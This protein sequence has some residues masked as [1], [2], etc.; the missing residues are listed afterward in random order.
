MSKLAASSL[1]HVSPIHATHEVADSPVPRGKRMLA[2]V[3]TGWWLIALAGQTI[4]TGYVATLYGVA[5]L[6]GDFPRWNDVMPRGWVSADVGGNIA[7]AAHLFFAAVVFA[8]GALQLSARVRRNA[9][10]LHRWN[11][12]FYLIAAAVLATT[13]L[14]LVFS[15]RAPGDGSQ[16]A[17]TVLNAAL[18]LAFG[19]MALRDA[20]SRRFSSHAR[21]ALRLLLAVAGVWFFRIGLMAWIILNRGAVGFDPDA[22]RGPTLTALAFAQTLLP[23]AILEG[24][25]QAKRGASGVSHWA[26]TAVLVLSTLLTLI[27]TAAATILMWWPHMRA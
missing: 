22:F 14:V 24:V 17:G 11:G 4:F 25:F 26:M 9:P 18:I 16:H 2:V 1:G 21:W 13:G 8:S 27:G 20:V 10:H 23:L 3:A 19:G 6:H 15:G 7:V 12:R 5:S